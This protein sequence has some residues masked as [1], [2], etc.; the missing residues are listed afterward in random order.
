MPVRTGSRPVNSAAR[1]GEHTALAESHCANRV[2]SRASWS[3]CGV[4]IVGWPA[5]L[6]SP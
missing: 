4:R 3:M 1:D 6:M 2:P 5:T